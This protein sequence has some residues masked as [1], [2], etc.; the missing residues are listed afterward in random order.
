MQICRE[1]SYK[2][3]KDTK[4]CKILNSNEDLEGA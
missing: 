4:I 3:E 2:L 1:F